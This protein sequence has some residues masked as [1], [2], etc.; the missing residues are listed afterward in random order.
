M[1]FELNKH[2]DTHTQNIY[3]HSAVESIEI[4]TFT[5]Q[6]FC[7]HVPCDNVSDTVCEGAVCCVTC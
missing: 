6:L 5:H 4:N 1:N 7:I 3:T 2:H